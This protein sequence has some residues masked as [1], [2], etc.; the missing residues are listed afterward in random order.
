[1]IYDIFENIC[2]ARFT[3]S[4]T[5]VGGVMADLPED[6]AANLQPVL[7]TLDDAKKVSA[8]GVQAGDVRDTW[9]RKKGFQSQ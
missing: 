4:Y 3:T 2:G 8:V 1:M 9:L 5:R 6:F 7:K